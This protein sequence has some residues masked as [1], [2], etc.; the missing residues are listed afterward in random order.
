MTERLLLIAAGLIAL[1]GCAADPKELAAADSA[2]CREY[3]MRP[4]T[5]AFANCRMTLDVER[6]RARDR[7]IYV[8][9]DG[10]GPLGPGAYQRF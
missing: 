2:K 10:Y 7:P 8:P 5:E 1:G 9:I 3:G 4:G 6:R